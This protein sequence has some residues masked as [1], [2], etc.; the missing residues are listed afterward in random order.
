M[1]H[2]DSVRI[3]PKASNYNFKG[4]YQMQNQNNIDG[5]CV[6]VF[7]KI[8]ATVTHELKNTLSII[9]ENAG[10]LNDLALMSGEDGSVPS[11]KVDDTTN[12]IAQQVTRSN[13]IIKNLNRFSHSGD[14]P[15][16]QANLFELLQ[17]M[18]DLTVRQAASASVKVKIQCPDDITINTN[19]LP[20]EALV[21][22][23]LETFYNLTDTVGNITIDAELQG[24]EV[25]IRIGN[26]SDQQKN[27]HEHCEPGEKEKLLAQSLEGTVTIDQGSVVITLAVNKKV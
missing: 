15:I 25:V 3:A 17:L 1:E 20:L 2:F 4:I 7:S 10:F 13:T 6:E 12:K 8:S 11:Q 14:T 9:N 19:L 5:L 24:T 23:E 16:S 27:P 21:F 26:D 18:V 22:Y